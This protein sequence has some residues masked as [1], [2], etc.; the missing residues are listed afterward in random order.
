MRSKILLGAAVMAAA[1]CVG[2]CA[3]GDKKPALE[4]DKTEL[5]LSVGET[6]ELRLVSPEEKA[7]SLAVTLEYVWTSS[8]PDTV[9]VEANGETAV[10]SA[11]AE[12]TATV[13]VTKGEEVI[14]TCAVTVVLPPLYYSVPEGT[15]VVRKG[16]VVTV[17]ADVP[18]ALAE[19]CV[20]ES[21]DPSIATVEH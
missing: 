19:S 5:T 4:L 12:G 13:T 9:S 18:D 7:V 1:L 17:H 15:I 6:A 10:L 3:G 16:R 21:S 14:G 2:A 11:L 8:A 20:W